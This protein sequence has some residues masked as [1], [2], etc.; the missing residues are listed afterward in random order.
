[1]RDSFRVNFLIVG[2]QKSGTTALA[3]FLAQHP[4]ICHSP[5]KELHF[6]DSPEFDDTAPPT[7]IDAEYRRGFPNFSGERLIGESTP[8]YMFRPQ[9]AARIQRYNP[10]MKLIAILREPAA[11]AI[12]QYQMFVQRGEESQSML[13]AFIRE[14]IYSRLQN[15]RWRGKLRERSY[16][17]R[18]FYTQQIRNLLRHFDRRRILFLRNEDLMN[19]HEATL[20]RI[21]EFLEVRDRSIVAPAAPVAVGDYR[22]G[23]PWLLPRAL[24]LFF[25]PEIR[26][27]EKLLGWNLISWRQPEGLRSGEAP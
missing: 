20:Q 24:R 26:R 7:Q 19:D 22:V 21:Y 1:M 5:R 23:T 27:L 6:F 14:G 3:S 10:R 9:I 8:I 11:R 25:A 17:A 4:E 16:L 13:Q 2:A 12:S 18:G 15:T